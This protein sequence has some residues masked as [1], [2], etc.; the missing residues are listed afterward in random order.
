MFRVM[1]RRTIKTKQMWKTFTVRSENQK[2]TSR[3]KTKE[4]RS[5]IERRTRV[6]LI[7]HLKFLFTM[8]IRQSLKSISIFIEPVV[9]RKVITQIEVNIR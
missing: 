6:I 2:R 1:K 5:Q 7:A 9:S 4:L 8:R 3:T